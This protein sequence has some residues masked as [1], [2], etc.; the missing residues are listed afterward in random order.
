M[1]QRGFSTRAIHGHE[2]PQAPGEPM[3]TPIVASTTFSFE[4]AAQF[5]RVMSEEEYGFLYAR[6]RNPTVVEL[7]A[8][9]ADLEGAEAALPFPR[10]WPRS[11][12]ASSPCS[13]RATR[14]FCARQ[15]YGSTYSFVESRVRRLGV[16]VD[17]RG[18]D[19]PRRVGAA[20]PRPLRRDPRE[21]RAPRR[22]PRCDR[23]NEGRRPARRR[24]HLR[25]PALCR[26]LEHRRR[27]RLRVGDEVPERPPRRHRRRR[28]GESP[29][30]RAVRGY[31]IDTGGILDP[32]PAYL[33]RRGL[34]TLGLR[35]ERQSA[36]AL[37]LARSSRG[38]R[39]SSA[40]TSPGSTLPAVRARAA[41][42]E[43]LGRHARLR[44]RGRP[45]CRRTGDGRAPARRPGHEPRRRRDGRVTTRPRRAT[46]SSRPSSSRRRAS[47]KGCSA[48]P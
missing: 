31:Q 13:R 22:R 7:G 44:G 5:G 27:S 1:S 46:G 36:N 28:R 9:L 43:R 30:D 32:F 3:N 42:A 23:R 8:R 12:R 10:G 39:R 47:L 18:R 17:L 24:Q 33:L 34:K 26:P 19:R 45:R 2:R 40:C 6:L 37:E 4:T 11:R 41:A 38:T 25:L 48:S 21:P 20:R 14:S 16:E 35:L 15:L 29:S